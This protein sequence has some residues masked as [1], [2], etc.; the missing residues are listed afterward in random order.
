MECLCPREAQ[1]AAPWAEAAFTGPFHA[2]ACFWDGARS[3][4]VRAVAHV[5]AQLTP[6]ALP[7]STVSRKRHENAINSA[8][9][10]VR[11]RGESNGSAASCQRESQEGRSHVRSTSLSQ[12][13]AHPVISRGASALHS[14]STCEV[15]HRWQGIT[16]HYSCCPSTVRSSRCHCGGT[17]SVALRQ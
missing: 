17:L 14:R 7:A 4:G 1:R 2:L 13:V 12:L 15:W 5:T 10:S 8:M 6:L 3:S 9:N 11:G 16:E